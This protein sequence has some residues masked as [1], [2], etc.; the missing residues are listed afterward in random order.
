MATNTKK[1]QQK[2]LLGIKLT[3]PVKKFRFH[4]ILEICGL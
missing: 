4:D 1:A 2:K 3:K